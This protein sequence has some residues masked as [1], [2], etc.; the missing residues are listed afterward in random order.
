MEDAE[1]FQPDIFFYD[2]KIW[3]NV[4]LRNKSDEL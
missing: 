2:L 4:I 3:F 1:D